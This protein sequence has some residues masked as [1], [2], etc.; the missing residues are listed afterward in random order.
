[1][2]LLGESKKSMK[3]HAPSGSAKVLRVTMTHVEV[4]HDCVSHAQEQCDDIE[5]IAEHLFVQRCC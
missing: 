2:H 4:V 3:E 1:M 5:L